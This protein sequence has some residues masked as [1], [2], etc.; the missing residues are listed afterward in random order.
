[1][2]YISELKNEIENLLSITEEEKQGLLRLV[3]KVE[4]QEEK[5]VF[6]HK[7]SENDKNISINILKKTVEEL[8]VQTE[9][10]HQQR[11]L[12][13]LKTI[14]LNEHLAALRYSYDELEQFTNIASHDIK[15]PLSRIGNYS[16]LLQRRFAPVLNG[17]GSKYL[18]TIIGNVHE[19]SNIISDFVEYT[20]IEKNRDIELVNVAELIYDIVTRKGVSLEAAEAK[21]FVPVKVMY[22][23]GN[24]QSIGYVFEEMIDNAIKFKSTDAPVIFI[25]LN[26]NNLEN[27]WIFTV[28]DNGIGIDEAYQEKVFLPFQ[29]IDKLELEGSGIGLAN[30][31]KIIN[32]HG[33]KIW[34]TK[35]SGL[36]CTFHFTVPTKIKQLLKH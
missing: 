15:G 34:F 9:A 23:Y 31:K 14:E 20:Q 19:M 18:E 24:R 33:G 25:D 21:V 35:N 32:L 26:K 7:R 30:C 1:M 12:V 4:K 29:R 6:Q 17:E 10:L 3:A 11:E 2:N 13:E 8:S 16:Q 22:I 5:L 36:G 27:E 28:R